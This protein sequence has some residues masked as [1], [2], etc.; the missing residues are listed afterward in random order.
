MDDRFPGRLGSLPGGSLETSL[1]RMGLRLP[2]RPSDL[3]RHTRSSVGPVPARKNLPHAPDTRT[4]R[5]AADLRRRARESVALAS[6]ASAEPRMAFGGVE[7]MRERS[8]RDDGGHRRPAFRRTRPAHAAGQRHRHHP[9]PGRRRSGLPTP[10][11]CQS[12]RPVRQSRLP[13]LRARGRRRDRHAEPS[14]A[15]HLRAQPP[16]RHG[17]AMASRRVY[18][19]QSA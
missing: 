16:P 13:T 14:T 4:P 15:H 8:L 18:T 9:G 3:W 6:K 10:E 7:A 19:G 11:A 5:N 2:V 17:G 12:A 1:R